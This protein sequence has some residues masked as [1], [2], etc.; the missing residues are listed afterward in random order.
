MIRK[1]N[2]LIVLPA[3]NEAKVIAKVILDIK[4]EG[5]E[6]ILVIDDCS[7]D[8]TF[9]VAKKAGAKVLR[10]IINRHGPGAPTMT[11]IIYARKNNYDKVVLMD[12]DGQHSPKD[13]KKLLEFSNKFDIVIGSRMIGDISQMPIQRKIANFVGSFVTCFFFGKF[14]YDS[15]SGFKVLNKKAIHSINLTFDTFEFSS[16]IIG[17]IRK[18]N[19]SVK[20]VPIEVIYTDH[21]KS[22]GQSILNGFK[23][24][25]KFI[26]KK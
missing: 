16:E 13:I 19:L 7:K 17:E 20:E 26:L 25:F 2:I 8:D 10:H 6:N 15:Q 9:E 4:K 24:I 11:G 23:M 14:V 1:S 21:S 3:F 22:K 5:F 12:S 18:H